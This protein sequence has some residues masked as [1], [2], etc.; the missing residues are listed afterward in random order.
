MSVTFV[1]GGAR[2]GKSAFAQD[3]A[4]RAAAKAGSRPVM[5]ATAEEL[6]DEMRARIAAHRAERGEGWRTL[7][8]P[9]DLAGAVRALEAEDSAVIDCLTLWLSNLLHAAQPVAAAVE[10]LV[11]ALA[12][13][14]A[15]I[16][17]VSNEV[18]MG[19][20]P[21]NALARAFRDEAGRLNRRMAA[22]ADRVVVMFAGLSLVMKGAAEGA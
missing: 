13:S 17:V 19:I 7:E 21:D 18:G 14:E 10:D 3:L 6:D 20:V 9:L 15:E 8:A 16:A 1:L 22:E 12:A 5:I 4:E 2:S 11:A